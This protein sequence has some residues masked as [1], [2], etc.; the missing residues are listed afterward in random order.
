M[1]MYMYVYIYICVCVCVCVYIYI[2]IY[3]AALEVL[4]CPTGRKIQGQ[5]LGHVLLRSASGM[6]LCPGTFHFFVPNSNMADLGHLFTSIS[7]EFRKCT[8]ASVKDS[9][10]PSVEPGC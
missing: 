5:K 2:Y 10:Y 7:W 1:H 4:P 3:K 8:A 6:L 9:F